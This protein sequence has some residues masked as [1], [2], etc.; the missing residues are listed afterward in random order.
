MLALLTVLACADPE[1]T[2]APTLAFLAPTDGEVV[3]AGT[4]AVSLLVEDFRLV[5]PVHSEGAPEGYVQLRVDGADL[6]RTG[7]TQAE[8]DLAPGEHV[9]EAELRYEDGDALEPA[10]IATVG[11]TAE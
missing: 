7:A 5:T 9:V 3:P 10:V 2:Q 4:V 6:L 8:V 11:V 1:S